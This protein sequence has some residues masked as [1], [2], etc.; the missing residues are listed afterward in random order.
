MRIKDTKGCLDGAAVDLSSEDEI[1]RESCNTHLGL[2]PPSFLT[3]PLQGIAQPVFQ[4]AGDAVPGYM[5]IAVILLSKIQRAGISS[6]RLVLHPS[7]LQEKKV[8]ERFNAAVLG[9]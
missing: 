8:P 7:I 5:V 1:A 4:G 2:L 9:L 3:Q 6:W